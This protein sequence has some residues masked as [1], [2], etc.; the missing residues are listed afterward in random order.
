MDGLGVNSDSLTAYVRP[1]WL[2]AASVLRAPSLVS[3]AQLVASF[4]RNILELTPNHR[5]AHGSLSFEHTTI[6]RLRVACQV[7]DGGMNKR[8]LREKFAALTVDL[9]DILNDN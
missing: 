5:H 9:W 2:H 7:E 4:L 6:R 1:H 3:N 8:V